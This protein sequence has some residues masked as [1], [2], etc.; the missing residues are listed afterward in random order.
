MT[1]RIPRLTSRIADGLGMALVVVLLTAAGAGILLAAVAIGS[2]AGIVLSDLVLVVRHL[3][4][5]P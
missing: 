1:P 3:G 5:A 4:R 2:H